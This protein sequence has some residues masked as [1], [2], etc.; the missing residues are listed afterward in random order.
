MTRFESRPARSGQ[1]DYYF[2]IDL[3]GHQLDTKVQA[4]LADL[5]GWTW[6]EAA[7]CIRHSFRFKDFSEAFAFMT[8]VALAAEKVAYGDTKLVSSGPLYQSLKTTG[9]KATV[10]F[11]SVGSGLVAKGGPLG[12]FAVAGPDGKF[13]WAQARIE[14]DKVEVW[15]EAVPTPVAVRYAW[16]DN[17]ATAN[18]YN[19]EGLPASTFTT[20]PAK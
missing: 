12:G 7:N 6:D 9:H 16:A 3:Q 10:S 11:A 17:P 20:E 2:Y 8:R 15:S 14:G 5:P 4:A 1:W 18:L 19:K 13:V